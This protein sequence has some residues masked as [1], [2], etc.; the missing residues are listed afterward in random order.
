MLNY[1]AVLEPIVIN[2]ETGEIK[3]M[4]TQ[5]PVT[6]LE[7]YD[8]SEYSIAG[9]IIDHRNGKVTIKMGKSTAEELLLVLEQENAELLFNNLTG[10]D[11]NAYV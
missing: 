6:K 10:E 5:I 11:F 1:Q 7:E 2:E 3:D 8:N 4:V 9:D